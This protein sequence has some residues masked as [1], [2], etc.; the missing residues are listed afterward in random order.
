[1]QQ[2]VGEDHA[3]P[4][5]PKT[6]HDPTCGNGN[7]LEE[8]LVE[9]L[10]RISLDYEQKT[11]PLDGPDARIWFGLVA[12]SSIS[13]IELAPDNVAECRARLV[14]VFCAW[15]ATYSDEDCKAAADEI[16]GINII[17]GNTLS[18]TVVGTGE[19]IHLPRW[20]WDLA[21]GIPFVSRPSSSR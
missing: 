17:H 15:V 14:E 8:V 2:L 16:V 4:W 21:T 20:H 19:P 10:D 1:M 3:Q 6:V 9:K 11:L 7:I 18:Y 12:L 13:G 5:P